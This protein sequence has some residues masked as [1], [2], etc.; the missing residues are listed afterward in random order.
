MPQDFGVPLHE[1]GAAPAPELAPDW[2]KTENFFCRRDEP[3]CGHAVP[4]QSEDRTKI[5][6]SC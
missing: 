1:S 3:Q 5:S 4:F 2:A 6:L